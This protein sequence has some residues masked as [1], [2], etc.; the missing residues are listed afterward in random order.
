MRIGELLVAAKLVTAEQIDEALKLQATQGG[1]LGQLLVAIGAIDAEAIDAFFFAIP[2]VPLTIEATGI[3]ETILLD[4]LL[5]LIVVRTL[6]TGS[7]MTDAIKL[8]PRTASDLIERAV[9]GEL[10]MALGPS[11]SGGS[12]AM[13]YGLTE[14][15]RK[16]AAEAMAVSSYIG[17]APVTLASYTERLVRQK[18]T[19]ETVNAAKFAYLLGFFG[20][21]MPAFARMIRK[22]W[23]RWMI[24]LPVGA[25]FF[26]DMTRVISGAIGAP[27]TAGAATMAVL[28]YVYAHFDLLA[29]L[30]VQVSSALLLSG[31]M[32]GQ[33]GQISWGIFIVLAVLA[34]VAWWC[35]KR[36]EAVAEGDPLAANPARFMRSVTRSKNLIVLVAERRAVA[37]QW[38]VS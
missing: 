25:L 33:K 4:L 12:S 28:W 37:F 35:R 21:G 9:E 15:G 14:R 11:Q 5:K 31:I 18:L 22:R 27:L 23:L 32:L 36:G 24:V 1:R 17:P 2:P 20:F 8:A 13:R 30:T 38:M 19:N 3:S 29:V 10:L 16:R 26:A 6:E 34:V 7:G